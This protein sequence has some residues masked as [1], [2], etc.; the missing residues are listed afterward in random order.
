[1]KDNKKILILG[2]SGFIGQALAQ[3]LSFDGHYVLGGVRKKETNFPFEQIIFNID[4][5]EHFPFQLLSKIDIIINACGLVGFK[6]CEEAPDLAYKYNVELV[7]IFTNK[8]REKFPTTMWVQISTNV[9]LG[10]IDKPATEKN[11]CNPKSIYGKSKLAG[12]QAV[13]N[14][15]IPYIIARTCDVYGKYPFISKR[16]RFRDFVIN[17]AKKKEPVSFPKEIISNPIS[18]QDF[19]AA[20]SFLLKINFSGYIN[21][22]GENILTRYQFAQF[23]A[24]SNKLSTKHFLST[25]FE[26]GKNKL[27]HN[28][29]V[30]DISQLKQLGFKHN[31]GIA[32]LKEKI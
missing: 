22:A 26:K 7:D 4:D 18:L 32:Q 21:I 17:I 28:Y 11:N 20:I 29:N 10:A 14:A 24:N 23:I 6:Q 5:I 3:K 13:S 15:G 30:L 9:V 2:A 12:E 25:S 27:F 8:I 31:Y 1:M 19:C 16:E